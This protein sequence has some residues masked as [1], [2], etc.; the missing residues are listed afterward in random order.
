[1]AQCYQVPDN[2]KEKPG[3]EERSC[4]AE[5]GPGP[6]QVYQAGEEVLQQPLLL[7]HPP[8]VGVD[9]AVF[10]DHPIPLGLGVDHV[11]DA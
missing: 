11:Q 10:G 6:G 7:I 5:D 2:C 3:K 4:K 8:V 9:L 1:M